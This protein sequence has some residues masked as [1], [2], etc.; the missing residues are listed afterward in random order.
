MECEILHC[1]EFR[2]LCNIFKG[3]VDRTGVHSVPMGKLEGTIS[4]GIP[5]R[6]R[7]DNIKTDLD[8][9]GGEGAN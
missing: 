5:R 3:N 7:E 4:M 1:I 6:R 2:K 8:G 9:I